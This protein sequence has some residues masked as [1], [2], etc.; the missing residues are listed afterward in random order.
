MLTQLTQDSYPA[1]TMTAGADEYIELCYTVNAAKFAYRKDGG[2]RLVEPLLPREGEHL[3]IRIY[4]ATG[5]TKTGAQRGDARLTPVE[6]QK[7]WPEVLV[8]ITQELEIW[9]ST[10]VFAVSSANLHG[11]ASA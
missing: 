4:A 5:T 9:S 11:V 7:H 2:S 3:C 10:A 6:V 1:I 8:P